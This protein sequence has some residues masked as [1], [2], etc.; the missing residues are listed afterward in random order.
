MARWFNVGSW[1]KEDDFEAIKS[2]V[3]ASL[4]S[5]EVQMEARLG[6]LPRRPP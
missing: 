1:S 5:C 3:E 2:S 4:I 6:G